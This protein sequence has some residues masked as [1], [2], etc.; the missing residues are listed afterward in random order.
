MQVETT[1]K[2]PFAHYAELFSCDLNPAAVTARLSDV[3]WDG[4]RNSRSVFWAG[5][6]AI[7]HPD[8]AIRALD[9]GALPPLPSPDVSVALLLESKDVVWQGQWK[10]FREM[11][12]GD[13]H[14]APHRPCADPWVSP[15]GTP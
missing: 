1:K 12:W 10:T 3:R 11:P 6:F 15:F 13:V 7:V 8:Y 14:Q 9:G 2:K 4:G 5:R